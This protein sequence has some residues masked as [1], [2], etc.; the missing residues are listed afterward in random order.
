VVTRGFTNAGNIVS[1]YNP[2]LNPTFTTGL[3]RTCPLL[4]YVHDPLIGVM[5]NETFATYNA[6]DEYTLTQSVTG[7][8]AMSTAA[9]GVLEIDSNSTTVVQGVNLQRNQGCTCFIPAAG[10]HIWAEFRFKI[11]DTF[12]DC[13]L[14]V[15]LA[16]TDTTIIA[17]SDNSS[18]DHIGWQC[19]T[20][21]GVLLFTSEKNTAGTTS[22]CAT[23]EE[24]TY[25]N[26]GFYVNGVTD[27]QQY[28]N[29]VATGTAHATAN[30]PIVALFPSFVCQSGG[31]ADPIMH[32][33]GYRV[34][35][36]K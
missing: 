19:V 1:H 28:V 26:L 15:G 7:T 32:V 8:A 2:S 36:L 33:Q 18:I 14:F 34:F 4:E 3:W 27:V 31:T 24:A 22:A 12:D 35:Q 30:I 16:A 5:L 17:A 11:V 25:I 23:L 29:G 10:K 13:E 21:D 20:D 6:T 9:P